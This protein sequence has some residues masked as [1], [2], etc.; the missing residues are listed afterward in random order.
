MHARWKS[1]LRLLGEN[2]Q[3]QNIEELGREQISIMSTS[4]VPNTLRCSAQEPSL[5]L[6]KIPSRRFLTMPL[7]NIASGH[8]LDIRSVSRILPATESI[9]TPSQKHLIQ[10]FAICTSAFTILAALITFYFFSRMKRRL[11]HKLV[12]LSILGCFIRGMWYFAFSAMVISGKIVTTQ[13]SFCQA[14]GFF[15]HIGNEMS[16][17]IDLG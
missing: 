12:M 16:G 10:T 5:L 17:K 14:T 1:G 3:V 7:N 4:R 9:Y 6:G 13:N 2:F 11:R 15:I 8:I